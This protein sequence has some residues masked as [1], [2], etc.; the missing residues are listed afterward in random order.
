MAALS[1][2]LPVSS[3]TTMPSVSEW[4]RPL[5]STLSQVRNLPSVVS[6]VHSVSRQE[7]TFRRQSQVHLLPAAQWEHIH[8]HPDSCQCFQL[9]R[10]GHY[11][12]RSELQYS[13]RHP[14]R[15][16]DCS[17]RLRQYHHS[18]HQRQRGNT[19]SGILDHDCS[20]PA[21]HSRLSC[22]KRHRGNVLFL[23]PDSCLCLRFFSLRHYPPRTELQYSHRR[24]ERNTD[25]SRRLRQYRHYRH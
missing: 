21:N 14:E 18:S 17:R 1:L 11:P 3:T 24:P 9:F 13:H 10:V 12:A 7:R 4:Y 15:N 19:A 8:L 25:Y 5:L 23:H 20:P 16:T 22:H 6:M 2:P